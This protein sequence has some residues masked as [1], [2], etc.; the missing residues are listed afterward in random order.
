ME[1]IISGA[2]RGLGKTLA[3]FFSKQNNHLH[4]I[5]RSESDLIKLKEK[6]KSSNNLVSIYPIDLGSKEE[7]DSL[8]I[9][10]LKKK[11]VLI[12]NLG[13]YDMDKPSNISEEKLYN[14]LNINL[15]S[16]IRLTKRVLPMMK[17]NSFGRIINIGSVMSLNASSI[18]TSY[19]ISKHAL[20]AWT[21]ALR[22]ELK[23][24]NIFVSGIYP[25]SINTSSWDGLEAD[26]KAMIQ[27]EDLA[28]L[29]GSLTKMGNSTLVEEIIINPRAF[30]A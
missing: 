18:A 6:I 2:S 25:G 16:A 15:Y 5:A 30:E 22:E 10:L 14:Q 11:I 20:K 12:N 26:R 3:N 8:T 13:I 4:L 29:I 19:S 7:I 23:E 17:E 1:V 9:N 21:D 27:T 24:D 28:E